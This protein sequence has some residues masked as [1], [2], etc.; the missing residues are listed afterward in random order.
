MSSEAEK[1]FK[2]ENPLAFAAWEMA[3]VFDN[4]SDGDGN[5]SDETMMHLSRLFGEVPEEYRGHVFVMFLAELDERNIQYDI[6]K[7]MSQETVH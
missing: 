6:T 5:V 1:Q 3:Q 2:D 7:F 4:G